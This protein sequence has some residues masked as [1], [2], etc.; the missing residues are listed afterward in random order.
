MTIDEI[1]NL[2]APIWVK[3]LLLLDAIE[4]DTKK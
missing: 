4:K 3:E 2:D 1:R